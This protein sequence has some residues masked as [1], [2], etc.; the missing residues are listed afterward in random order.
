MRAEKSER[1]REECGATYVWVIFLL[2]DAS[3]SEFKK[4]RD[5]HK[6][7]FVE[8]LT[9]SWDERASIVFP[10]RSRRGVR[11]VSPWGT[12]AT[13]QSFTWCCDLL[14]PESGRQRAG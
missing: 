11:G 7:E 1:D 10:H 3:M 2:G 12:G 9:Y 8:T 13:L 5:S 14:N 6:I 4:I